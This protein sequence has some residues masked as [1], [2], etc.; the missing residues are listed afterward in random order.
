MAKPG[1]RQ[2]CRCRA[3][4]RRHDQCRKWKASMEHR[5]RIPRLRPGRQPRPV[6]LQL[7]RFRP[8]DSPV[9]RVGTY[10]GDC[11]L[12]QNLGNGKFVDVARKAG[13]TTNAGNGK[14]RWNTGFAFLDY[15]RDGNLD[16]FVS[17]YIDFDL[18]TAP[19]SKESRG[20]RE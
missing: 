18:K 12:W 19:R 6:C 2:V 10:W 4:S 20:G 1:K 17:N 15:D 13:V 5:L 16:L 11:V 9:T 8:E 3:K 7:H 14:R